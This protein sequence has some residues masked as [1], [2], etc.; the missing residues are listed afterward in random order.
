MRRTRNWA[1]NVTYG[2]AEIHA[3]RSLDD[4][5]ATVGRSRRVRALGTGH[6]FSDVADSPGVLVSLADL[7]PVVEVDSAAARVRVAAGMRYADLAGRLDRAGFALPN[8]ASLPHLSVAGACATATHGSGAGNGCLA[9][10][11][12]EMEMVTAGGDL[13]TVGRGDPRFPGMVVGLGLLGV[14]SSLTLDLVPTFEV[15]QRVF[16]WLAPDVVAEHVGAVMSGGY[17][18]S[19]F[20]DWRSPWQVWLKQR[21]GDPEPAVLAE[22][23]FT[24]VPVDGPRHPVPGAPAEACTEQLGVPGRWFARLPHFRPD[25]T[26]SAGAE[27]Q[28]E[29]MVARATAGAALHALENLRERIHPV[30]HV[31]EVRA[32][33]ADD[34]WLS[35]FHRRDSVSIH[36][37]WI[38][39]APAVLPVVALVEDRLAPFGARPH[40]GKVFTTPPATLASLYERLPAFRD[41]AADHDPAG[42]FRNAFTARNLGLA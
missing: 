16:E 10:A 35:P 30:L 33:A 17:S 12:V 11:V 22:P 34:L 40:W 27:L 29:Y 3:P 31:C 19:L 8:L 25:R 23:W 24:A 15:R 9:T 21:T 32:V 37:T 6:S 36:F 41:L 38:P 2:A 28:S 14:V 42:T 1:G 4:L 26:P 20:T 18:V 5:R 13:V 7:P 39:D